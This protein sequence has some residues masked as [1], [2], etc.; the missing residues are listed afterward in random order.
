MN[1]NTNRTT[2]LI[3]II[4]ILILSS[5]IIGLLFLK[6]DSSPKEIENNYLTKATNTTKDDLTILIKDYYY[7]NNL[8]D[9]E[10]LLNWQINNITYIGYNEENKT[11]NYQ[12][13]GS[14]K[15]Q[16]NTNSCIYLSQELTTEPNYLVYLEVTIDNQE[17]QIKTISQTKPDNLIEEEKELQPNE[18]FHQQLSSLIKEYFQENSLIDS[19]KLDYW[20]I[21]DIEYFKKDNDT[22]IYYAT[23]N[24][25]C[26]DDSDTCLYNE[27][28]N[29]PKEDKSYDFNFYLNINSSSQITSI[30]NNFFIPQEELPSKEE[31]IKLTKDYFNNNYLTTPDNLLLWNIS[32]VT[33]IGYYPNNIDQKIIKLSGEYQCQDNS[34]DCL[35]LEQIGE[36]NPN[37]TYPFNIYITLNNNE[38]INIFSSLI[39]DMVTF[40]E[41]I[42]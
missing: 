27:Q 6:K 7:Q 10:N 33:Y 13:E 18:E 5:I 32:N 34:S 21:L 31:L 28:S 23:T 30:S 29:E 36:Q 37:N 40:N 42:N 11:Y 12:V 22:T 16:D 35:Y 24:Y 17:Y 41:P 8:L 4:I 26:Q 25:H 9:E 15:C 2:L 38:I 14:Y 1:T 19:S 20:N 39:G 3:I